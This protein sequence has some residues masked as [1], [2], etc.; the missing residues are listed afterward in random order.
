M[1]PRNL[2]SALRA[3]H[4]LFT[5]AGTINVVGIK[6]TVGYFIRTDQREEYLVGNA[7]EFTDGIIEAYSILFRCA[8]NYP[9]SKVLLLV[10]GWLYEFDPELFVESES[11]FMRVKLSLNAGRPLD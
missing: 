2:D 8:L 11:P 5:F 3:T 7:E 10:G 1:I 9:G 6:G 4:K